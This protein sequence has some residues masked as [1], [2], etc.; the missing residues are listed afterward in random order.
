MQPQERIISKFCY[1]TELD[2]LLVLPAKM[3]TLTGEIIKAVGV[4]SENITR[5]NKTE[6]M[7]SEGSMSYTFSVTAGECVIFINVDNIGEFEIVRSKKN[8]TREAVIKALFDFNSKYIH[9]K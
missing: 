2:K 8:S 7:I 4:N 1:I 3:N 5:R 6:N 9:N